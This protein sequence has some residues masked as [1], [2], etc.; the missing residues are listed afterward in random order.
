V[1]APGRTVGGGG[2][3][4]AHSPDQGPLT[5]D[6]GAVLDAVFAGLSDR[7]RYLRFHAPTPRLTGAM[8][9]ALLDLDGRDRAG[10]VAEA[11]HRRA[12]RPVGIARLARTGGCRAELAVEV[13]D[14]WQGRGVGRRLLGALGELADSLGYH[15]LHGDVLPGNGAVV[16]LLQRVFPGARPRWDDGTIR[17]H[18]PL[19]ADITQD[20]LVAALAGR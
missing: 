2:H 15:E 6:D 14:A 10:L 16:H 9:R 4:H 13:V 17:V 5:R 20:D 12:W 19:R 11:R 18:C 8:R 7:S 1:E 3:R